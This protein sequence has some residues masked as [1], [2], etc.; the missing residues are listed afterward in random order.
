MRKHNI[1]QL[2]LHAIADHP[3]GRTKPASG[4]VLGVI[5]RWQGCDSWVERQTSQRRCPIR[6]Y[7]RILLTQCD[8]IC[9]PSAT[10]SCFFCV[11]AP[12]AVGTVRR[13]R[14]YERTV[15]H[16]DSIKASP[17]TA[18]V[19]GKTVGHAI[20]RSVLSPAR[21]RLAGT[22]LISSATASATSGPFKL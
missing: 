15:A 8:S 6:Q 9:E 16:T 5:A 3:R 4:R 14:T 1:N 11:V 13:S 21:A 17:R 20:K 10:P 18:H 19:P 12:V 7:I 22:G 2:F